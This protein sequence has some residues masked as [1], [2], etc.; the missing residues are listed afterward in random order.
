MT[1][2]AAAHPLR[3]RSGGVSVWRLAWRNL[4]RN[5]RRTWLT[6]GGIG[7]AVWLLVFSMSIQ[8]GSFEIMIDNAAR[9][10]TGHVQLQHPDYADDPRIE[11]RLRDV[12]PLID[13]VGDMPRVTAV[14]PRTSGFALV[15]AGERSFGAQ[16]TGVDPKR[17]A[18][19]SSLPTMVSRGR[20]LSAPGEAVVGEALARNLGVDVGDEVVMLGTALEGGVAAAVADVVGIVSTGQPELDRGLLQ[21]HIDDFRAAWNLGAADAHALVILTQR[22]EAGVEVAD[23]LRT[24]ERAALDWRELMPEAEQTIEFKRIG[25]QLFF[26]LITVI[27]AFSVVNT[28]M[29]TV[30]ERT[31]EIGMLTALGMRHGAIVRQLCL[32]AFWLAV[33][34]VALGLAVAVA[35]VSVLTVTGLPLPADAA[36]IMARYNMPDRMYPAFSVPAAL[37]AVAV[38]LAGT[39]LAVLVPAL[40]VRRLKPV[41]ALRALE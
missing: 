33:L 6:A 3:H 25:A 20:Y 26:A 13:E 10:M 17:E 1:A 15:S 38:M 39:Q 9:L 21:I 4:W 11:H 18:V 29:M 41:E 34:G 37:V 27:V 40:R 5:P 7:F 8:D 23:A 35:V 36:E 31:P 28:F 16:V 22:V 32:E 14:L 12:G 19:A 24:P 30:F 2:V